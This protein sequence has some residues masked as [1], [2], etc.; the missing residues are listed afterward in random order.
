MSGPQLQ[1]RT[2]LILQSR[3]INIQASGVV[4]TGS[5]RYR[6]PPFVYRLF[7]FSWICVQAGHN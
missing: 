3:Y 6:K 2:G 7:L 5:L 1:T 4:I